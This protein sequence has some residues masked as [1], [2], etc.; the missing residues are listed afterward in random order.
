M[1]PPLVSSVLGDDYQKI[2]IAV[3]FDRSIQHPNR[4]AEVLNPQQYAANRGVAAL[5]VT[6][7]ASSTGGFFE[8][9]SDV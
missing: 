9:R 1:T 8:S 7:R 2:M 5:A 6:F 4:L 3:S